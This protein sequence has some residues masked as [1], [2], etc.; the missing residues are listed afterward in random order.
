M[1]KN[2]TQ[3]ETVVGVF[4]NR[5]QAQRAI[6]ELKSAGFRGEDIGV[7]MQNREG[8]KDL[9]GETGTK[10]GEAAGVG[11]TT[12]GVLGALGGLLVG[13]G[14]LA[15]PGIGP[16]VAA[17]PLV[18]A[19]GPLVGGT[20][21]GAVI[22]A[23]AGAIAGA[24]VGLGIP[25]DEAR[26]YEQRFQ[27]GGILVTVKAGAN[28]YNEAEG[29]LR[30]AGAEDIEFG[31]S[32]TDANRG[33]T[34]TQG[35]TYGQGQ[36][37]VQGQSGNAG[38][39]QNQGDQTGTE[40]TRVPLVEENINVNK[41]VRNAGEVAIG[42]RV[43][44]EQVNVPVDVSHEEVTVSRHAV[45]RPLQEGEAEFGQDQVIR[46]PVREETV[47]VQKQARV[48][49]EVEINK[50]VVNERR[51]VQDTVRREELDM[52]TQGNVQARNQ[53][54]QSGAT[55]NEDINTETPY[56]PNENTSYNQ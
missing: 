42:K 19:L 10:A 44:E 18:A 31:Q 1:A 43:V 53:G 41:G 30:N 35:Q 15:I 4:Q 3:R 32:A 6:E 26:I 20:A 2:R 54:G 46:V 47:D 50:Q 51:N 39:T 45:D 5:D 22:G 21:T 14:A 49:E 8:A 55:T 9:A 40:R 23:G 24:L 27:E 37:Y 12:G 48:K 34:Y 36:S 28:R 29:I 17:G 56:N 11:A 33:Q 7:L 13:L 16:V 38:Y 52:N 25:E